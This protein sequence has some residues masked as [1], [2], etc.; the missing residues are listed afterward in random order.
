MLGGFRAIGPGEGITREM[1]PHGNNS[2]LR[3][4]K[5]GESSRTGI[6]HKL[7]HL[8]GRYEGDVVGL[9]I[10]SLIKYE[11]SFI[12]YQCRKCGTIE[13]VHKF[14]IGDLYG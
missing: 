9:K 5:S 1:T 10:A 6:L 4:R 12:G 13:G 3:D 11:D 8:I 14:D 7:A 2:A